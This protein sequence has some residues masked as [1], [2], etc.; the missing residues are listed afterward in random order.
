[1]EF[2]RIV[3]LIE[4]R[5]KIILKPDGF[6]TC[7]A[8]VLSIKSHRRSLLI[9]SNKPDYKLSIFLLNAYP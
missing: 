8:F 9:M 1:M 5:K 6:I 4:L 7:Q 3:R 2:R